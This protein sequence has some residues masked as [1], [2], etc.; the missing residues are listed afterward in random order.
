MIAVVVNIVT[1]FER[2]KNDIICK[3]KNRH[4]ILLYELVYA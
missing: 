4:P 2:N 3:P 1:W